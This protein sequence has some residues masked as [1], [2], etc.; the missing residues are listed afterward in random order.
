[1]N[2]PFLENAFGAVGAWIFGRS[3]SWAIPELLSLILSALGSP[4]EPQTRPGWDSR[5]F[6]AGSS[7]VGADPGQGGH[8][9]TPP[10]LQPGPDPCSLQF[11][12]LPEFACSYKYLGA[13]QSPRR[14]QALFLGSCSTKPYC[15]G[16]GQW[17]LLLGTGGRRGQEQR[18][19]REPFHVDPGLDPPPA[20]AVPSRGSS[21]GLSSPKAQQKLPPERAGKGKSNIYGPRQSSRKCLA[22]LK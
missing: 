1:M 12:L 6:W 14:V 5:G 4:L 10:L 19:A 11:Q 22:V 15:T 17:D 16:A 20:A 3:S 8:P 18:G 21:P 7:G 9:K 2:S 13:Q